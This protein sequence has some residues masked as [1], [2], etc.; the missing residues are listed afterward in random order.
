M[1]SLEG[2]E[3]RVGNTIDKKAEKVEKRQAWIQETH[4][5]RKFFLVKVAR[6]ALQLSVS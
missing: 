2:K 1:N 4:L 3:L 5:V 6:I